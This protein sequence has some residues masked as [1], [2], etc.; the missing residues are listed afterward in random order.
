MHRTKPL[1]IYMHEEQQNGAIRSLLEVHGP[2]RSASPS[3]SNHILENI[4]RSYKA[5]G[6]LF[7]ETSLVISHPHV[8]VHKDLPPSLP[9]PLVQGHVLTILRSFIMEQTLEHALP[10]NSQPSKG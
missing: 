4:E 6:D 2:L 1:A 5:S 7:N 10:I 8:R 3:S 9:Y